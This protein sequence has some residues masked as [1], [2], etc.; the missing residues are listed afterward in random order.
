MQIPLHLPPF[1]QRR[2]HKEILGF[3]DAA[4]A[5][6]APAERKELKR[7]DPRGGSSQN[8]TVSVTTSST[9]KQRKL[10]PTAPSKGPTGRAK[11]RGETSSSSINSNLK[12]TH[13]QAYDRVLL[14]PQDRYISSLPKVVISASASVSDGSG[15]KLN[16]SIGS[17]VKI[18]PPSYDDYREGDVILDPFFL[19]VPK[20][21]PRIKRSAK[22]RKETVA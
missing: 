1:E 17:N 19:D 11:G 22:R 18:P 12:K 4:D 13:S 8:A 14:T 2:D 3:E 9:S 10:V 21:K 15:K 20:I 16:Y 7:S 6:I 5:L